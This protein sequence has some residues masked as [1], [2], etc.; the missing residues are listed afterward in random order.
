MRTLLFE[1]LRR[2]LNLQQEKEID[3]NPKEGLNI[4]SRRLCISVPSLRSRSLNYPEYGRHTTRTMH[5]PVIHD[6]TFRRS[7]LSMHGNMFKTPCSRVL[8]RLITLPDLNKSLQNLQQPYCSPNADI[9]NIAEPMFQN[10]TILEQQKEPESNQCTL[11]FHVPA[12]KT[13]DENEIVQELLDIVH[14]ESKNS[15]VQEGNSMMNFEELGIKIDHSDYEKKMVR[16]RLARILGNWKAQEAFTLS[17]LDSWVLQAE[18]DDSCTLK[19]LPFN[20]A[21]DVYQIFPSSSSTV[22]PPIRQRV[23]ESWRQNHSNDTFAHID[24]A[25]EEVLS[26]FSITGDDEQTVNSLPHSKHLLPHPDDLV[27]V[28]RHSSTG[29]PK[30]FN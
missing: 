1:P 23:R 6:Y 14:A 28:P 15:E 22:V 24:E 13:L 20:P 27:M 4:F 2:I 12:E 5:S 18:I 10:E 26:I 8:E 25:E 30:E 29:S 21:E 3:S 11:I 17:S 7:N 9:S 19:S 16:A